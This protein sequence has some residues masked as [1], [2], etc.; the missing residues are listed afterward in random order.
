[1]AK[2][3]LRY[4]SKGAI[5]FYVAKKDMEETILTSEFDSE[6]KW[7]GEVKLSNGETWFIEPG[8]KKFPSEVVAVRRGD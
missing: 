2:V 3:M 8:V 7:G 5:S 1:M 6:E 4:D